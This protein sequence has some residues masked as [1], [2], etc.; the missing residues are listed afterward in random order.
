MKSV[1]CFKVYELLR[2]KDWNDWADAFYPHCLK[3][4]FIKLMKMPVLRAMGAEG[5]ASAVI[6]SHPVVSR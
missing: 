1:E 6:V 2:S 5:I 4:F 3:L